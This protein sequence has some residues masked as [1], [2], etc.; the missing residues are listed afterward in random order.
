[1]IGSAASTA[2][3]QLQI[4]VE[5]EAVTTVEQPV[6]E[7]SPRFCSALAADR[8]VQ[9]T[10]LVLEVWDRPEVAL[11]DPPGERSDAS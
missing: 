6:G 3:R 7:G 9:A 8:L 2:Q 5:H 1:L 11:A 10:L 4:L